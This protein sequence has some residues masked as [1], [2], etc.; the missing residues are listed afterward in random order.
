[1]VLQPPPRTDLSDTGLIEAIVADTVAS[2]ILDPEIP[3]D[4]HLDADVAWAVAPVADTFRNVVVGAQ[5]RPGRRRP[6][7]RG[8]FVTR[9]V[10]VTR[11][12]CGGSHR[13]IPRTIWGRG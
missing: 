8:R 6:P 7:D 9:T 10:G 4:A 3:V 11:D 2:R 1:M 13:S 12:S 5:F